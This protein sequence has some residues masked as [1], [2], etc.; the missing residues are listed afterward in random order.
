MTV[1]DFAKAKKRDRS[2]SG[3]TGRTKDGRQE[4]LITEERFND[5][6]RQCARL[7]QDR[8]YI[9]GVLPFAMTCALDV[10]GSRKTEDADGAAVEVDGVRHTPGSLVFTG[11][12]RDRVA[13]WLDSRAL[14]YKWSPRADAWVVTTCPAKLAQRI[15]AVASE[16]GFR[17][18]CGIARTPLFVGGDVVASQGW[19]ATTGMILDLPADLPPIPLAPT[20]RDAKKVVKTLL[21]PFRGY[22]KDDSALRPALIAAALTAALRASLPT[23]PAVVW[24]GNT[25]GAGKGKGARA[26]AVI[27]TGG[28]PAMTAEGHSNEETEKRIAAAILQ[29]APAILLDNLQRTLASATL[30]SILTDPVARIRKFGSLSDDVVTECRALVLI[31]ANN[32]TLRR[33]LLRRTLPVRLVVPSDKPELRHFDFDPVDEAR[34]YRAEILSAA[35]TIARAWYRKRD[36]PE[37]ADICRKTLGSFE[38]WA[39]LVAGAVEWL[40]GSNPIDQIRQRKDNDAAAAAERGVIC[41]LAECFPELSFSAAEAATALTPEAWAAVLSF[42]GEKPN[43]RIAGNWLMRRRDRSFSI[44]IEG[45]KCELVTLRIIATDRRGAAIWRVEHADAGFHAEPRSATNAGKSMT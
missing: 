30:E 40:T 26:L 36:H 43:G 10:N 45:E 38:E 8:I 7:L 4:I 13:F 32:A 9:R 24:D 21:R 28:L 42:K 2:R 41:Q 35:F 33:D 27:A 17:P 20:R 18:C 34:Q 37:H 25:V 12:D 15:I 19:N 3:P 29:G 5:L 39:A 1:E 23:A 6:V 14:F 31:T 16:L 11:A 22:L 44:E